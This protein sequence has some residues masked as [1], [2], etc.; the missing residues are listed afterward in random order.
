VQ[1]A[2]ANVLPNR[3]Q[4]LAGRPPA[5]VE[6]PGMTWGG[7]MHLE[8]LQAPPR[9]CNAKADQDMRNVPMFWTCEEVDR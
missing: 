8:A 4:A 9:P 5:A 3:L 6:S 1:I 2:R 7:K